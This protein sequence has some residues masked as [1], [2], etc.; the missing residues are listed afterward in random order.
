MRPTAS[1]PPHPLRVRHAFPG[2]VTSP[3]TTTAWSR[4]DCQTRRAQLVTLLCMLKLR[5]LQQSARF[6][7]VLTVASSQ[8]GMHAVSVV[9]MS[10]DLTQE[11]S[12]HCSDCQQTQHTLSCATSSITSLLC[13]RAP[14]TPPPD[15]LRPKRR[16]TH[17]RVLGS[18]WLCPGCAACCG[19]KSQKTDSGF[20]GSGRSL[21]TTQA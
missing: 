12:R 15:I 17:S 3:K 21:G 18:E 10:N 11:V 14:G 5:P 2:T 4:P 20:N 8:D 7:I 6:Q 9:V 1:P 19:C 13:F 16:R